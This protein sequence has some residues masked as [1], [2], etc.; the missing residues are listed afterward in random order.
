MEPKTYFYNWLYINALTQTPGLSKVVLEYDAFSDI[1]FN[2]NR[3]INCQAEVAA[4][5]VGLCRSGKIDDALKDKEA[6]LETVYN[7]NAE[8][9]TE[10]YEQMNLSDFLEDK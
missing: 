8:C 6:F 9:K 3:S 2:P 5:Y 4:I 7:F 10:T 1:E